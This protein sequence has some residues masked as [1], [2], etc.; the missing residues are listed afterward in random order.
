MFDI[1]WLEASARIENLQERLDKADQ[2]PEEEWEDC[3]MEEMMAALG[4]EQDDSA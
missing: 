4:G 2:E 3:T 1:I